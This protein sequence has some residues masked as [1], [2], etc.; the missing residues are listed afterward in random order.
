MYTAVLFAVPFLFQLAP[1]NS[2]G[3]DSSAE[4]EKASPSAIVDDVEP[5]EGPTPAPALAEPQT[6]AEDLSVDP[7]LIKFKPGKGLVFESRDGNWGMA[8]RTRIQLRYTY[9]HVDASLLPGDEDESSQLLNVR[10][11]RFQVAGHFFGKHNKYKLQ[12]AL[13]PSDINLGVVGG[14]RSP[15]LDAIL[16]FDY[17]RDATLTAGQFMVP[18]NRQRIVSS[19]DFDLVDRSIAGGEFQLDRDIGIQLSSNDLFG[20]DHFRYCAAIFDGEGRDANVLSDSGMLYVARIEALPMGDSKNRWDY[21]E[22]DLEHTES[23]RVS[24]GLAY[25]YEHNAVRNRGV[26]GSVPS[27]G[28]TTDMSVATAD[29]VAQWAGASVTSEFYVRRATRNYGDATVTDA[30]GNVVP[31]AQ[32]EPRNGTGWFIQAGYILPELPIGLAARY[33]SVNPSPSNTSMKEVHEIGGGPSWYIGGHDFKLQLDYF[34]QYSADIS[35]GMDV[36]RTQI[37]AGF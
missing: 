25:A 1:S 34:R 35:A 16:E 31:A 36:I 32:E 29:F 12:L 27:D 2:G 5:A 20:W 26:M 11:A 13:S 18:W 30:A 21:E 7:E 17:L 10:R 24:L 37:S 8:I 9:E 33:S 28:G 14:A 4:V 22:G 23:P 15:V 6:P 3:I 19:G